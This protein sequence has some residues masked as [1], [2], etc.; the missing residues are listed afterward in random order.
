MRTGGKRGALLIRCVENYCGA[1]GA[2][3]NDWM[4]VVAAEG[5]DLYNCLR[6][7]VGK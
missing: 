6:V 2:D 1:I 7:C 5:L 3:F 4:R